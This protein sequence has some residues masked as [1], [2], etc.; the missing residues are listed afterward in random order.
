MC[1]SESNQYFNKCHWLFVISEATPPQK[2]L[3]PQEDSEGVRYLS[4]IK[5]LSAVTSS[6][7]Q[8]YSRKKPGRV[9]PQYLSGNKASADLLA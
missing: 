7:W 4:S 8:P 3:S 2:E 1:L 9:Q 6:E 5:T